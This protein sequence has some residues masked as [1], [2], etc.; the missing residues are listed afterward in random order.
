MLQFIQDILYT[1]TGF[2]NKLKLAYTNP[3]PNE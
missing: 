1:V 3:S 2:G